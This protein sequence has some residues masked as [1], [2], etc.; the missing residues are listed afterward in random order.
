MDALHVGHAVGE[1][2]KQIETGRPRRYLERRLVRARLTGRV[3]GRRVE[4]D[5]SADAGSSIDRLVE[6]ALDFADHNE[7]HIR[8]VLDGLSAA[9]QGR[10]VIVVE[11]VLLARILAGIAR[12]RGGRAGRRRR[13]G[14]DERDRLVRQQGAHVGVAER[15]RLAKVPSANLAP[16]HSCDRT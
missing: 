3:D 15:V 12:Q 5:A 13:R 8:R 6:Q 9:T 4:P 10:L 14:I 7:R 2:A 1:L 11:Q 16:Q